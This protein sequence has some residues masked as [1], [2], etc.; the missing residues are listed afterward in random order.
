MQTPCQCAQPGFCPRHRCVKPA[1]WH[2]LC[3][4]RAD[5]FQLWEEGHG[6]GQVGVRPPCLHLGAELREE[7]C[8][9]CRGL[10]RLKVFA[11]ALHEG[12]TLAKQLPAVACCA[13]CPD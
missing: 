9:S 1:A 11:C 3:R 10:V 4:T 7:P 8:P 5:Y 13:T 6:P 12:C 2:A